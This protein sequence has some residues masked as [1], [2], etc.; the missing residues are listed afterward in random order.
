MK[1]ISTLSM[2]LV[3]AFAFGGPAAFTVAPA[4]AG[5]VMECIFGLDSCDDRNGL[6]D[7][8]TGEGLL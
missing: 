3:M 6:L 4:H 5:D 8:R 1:T 7:G 2:A